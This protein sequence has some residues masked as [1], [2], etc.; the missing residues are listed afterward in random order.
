M[1]YTYK[2]A[3]KDQAS[4]WLEEIEAS[5][6]K[7]FH[8]A[9]YDLCIYLLTNCDY[10]HAKQACFEIINNPPHGSLYANLKNRIDDLRFIDE[11]RKNRA[12][13]WSES[14]KDSLSPKEW[15]WMMMI[16]QEILIWHKQKLV[17][18]REA[19]MPIC[20]ILEYKS[21][22]QDK[23]TFSPILDNLLQG[24]VK[25]YLKTHEDVEAL[26]NFL[27]GYYNTLVRMREER[28]ESNSK[29]DYIEKTA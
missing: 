27:K 18:T 3:T 26:S 13:D 11:S 23:N 24:S 2:T 10:N 21:K 14:R 29:K 6:E 16:T 28:T 9:T 8:K 1:T 15:Q 20:D 19:T 5:R 12:Q 17:T 25:P 22:Y 7:G 4:K